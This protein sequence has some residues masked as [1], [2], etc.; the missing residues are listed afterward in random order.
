MKRRSGYFLAVWDVEHSLI[1]FFNS[2]AGFTFC[3]QTWKS[4]NRTSY[5]FRSLLPT[6]LGI[7]FVQGKNYFHVN[8]ELIDNQRI[9]KKLTLLTQRKQVVCS[10][11][12]GR[13]YIPGLR[14]D[15]TKSERV[16]RSSC[17][18]SLANSITSAV[19]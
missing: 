9:R 16:V 2:T 12:K 14:K 10:L 13:A 11:A 19:S 15:L 7:L 5:F 6:V 4:A 3:Y 1:F 18:T 17:V 8:K